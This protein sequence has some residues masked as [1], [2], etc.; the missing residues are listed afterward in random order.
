MFKYN[1]SILKQEL[2][3]FVRHN[4]QNKKKSKKKTNLHDN[5]LEFNYILRV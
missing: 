2:N 1:D 3:K 4:N 5:Y